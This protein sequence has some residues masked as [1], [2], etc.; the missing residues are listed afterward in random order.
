MCTP[1]NR[2]KVEEVSNVFMIGWRVTDISIQRL[3]REILTWKRVSQHENV[4]DFMG[5]YRTAHDPP[6][7]VLPY[8][9]NNNLLRYAAMRHPSERITLVSRRFCL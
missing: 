7:L 8:Y 4:A 5:I 6:Y 2:R 3:L 9:R 1:E